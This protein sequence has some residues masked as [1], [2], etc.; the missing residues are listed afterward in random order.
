MRI[1]IFL[2]VL[3]CFYS[4]VS[5]QSNFFNS[6]DAYL[7]Q[8]RPNDTPRVFAQH[9]LVPDS[10]IAMGR[11]AFSANGKEFYY[12]NSIHWFNAKG[13]KIRYFKYDDNRWQGPF[14][15]N[16]DYSTPTFSVDGRSMYFAGKGD[17]K[18]SY[19]WISHRNKDGWTDPYVFLKKGY[20]LYNFMPTNSGTFYVGSNGDKGNV[21]DYSTYDF[22]TLTISKTDTVIKSLGPV[23]NTPAFDGDFYVAS[24][25]S[26]M[27]ISYKEKPDYECE[28]GITFRK[29]DHSWTAPLN[30]G[31]LI[32][33]GDAHRWGEYVT[34][35]GK[36]LIYTK[37]TSEKDCCLYW[38]RFD[39]LKAKLKKEA[40]G[41]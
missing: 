4:C 16:Y 38:V 41:K 27:I 28:L 3:C 30:L 10:G 20:G 18:H 8:Q 12:G 17:G 35:D 31:P 1:L 11:S 9:M 26:Y 22:C 25:E 21:R 23:I 40:L 32:N 6:K 33:D 29:P 36:Y 37:G 24:D 7:G 2:L 19:V 15:L 13:N 5:A 39:T 14:V 34:P